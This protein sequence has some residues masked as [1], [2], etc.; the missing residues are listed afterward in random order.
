MQ[1]DTDAVRAPAAEPRNLV[2]APGHPLPGDTAGVR[3]APRAVRGDTGCVQGDSIVY[4][5]IL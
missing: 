5:R 4:T 3:A 1:G 2:P